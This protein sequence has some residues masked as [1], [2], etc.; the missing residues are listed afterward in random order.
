MSISNLSFSPANP[1]LTE[2]ENKILEFENSWWR[3]S[4]SK[5][6]SIKEE[7]SLTPIAYYQALNNLIDRDDALLAAP[8]LVKRLR[9]LRESRLSGR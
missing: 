7:F 2:L 8:I 4:S 5:E 1:G 9:R 6:N 3:F